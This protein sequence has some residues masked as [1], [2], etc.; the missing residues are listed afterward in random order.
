MISYWIQ[1]KKA[2]YDSYSALV[3]FGF[4]YPKT[5]LV[6]PPSTLIVWPVT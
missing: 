4:V 5:P 1:I 2:E 6:K 3:F